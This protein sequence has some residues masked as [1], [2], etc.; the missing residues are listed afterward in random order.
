MKSIDWFLSVLELVIWYGFFYC[1]LN[2][3]VNPSNLYVSALI[4]TILSTAGILI[5]PWFRNTSAWKRMIGK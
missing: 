5:C 4:L 1:L 2:A 3:I